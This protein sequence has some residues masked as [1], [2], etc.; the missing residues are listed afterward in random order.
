M[1]SIKKTLTKIL[2]SLLDLS[3]RMGGTYLP[4]G[5]NIDNLT[6]K[7]SGWWVYDQS[8]LSGTFPLATTTSRWGMLKHIQGTS[9]NNGIQIIRPTIYGQNTIILYIRFKGAKVWGDWHALGTYTNR[10][11][12]TRVSNSY[13]NATDVSYLSAYRKNGFL[14]LRGNFHLSASM[15]NN[16]ADVKVATISGWKAISSS[17]M[18]IPAQNGNATLLLN[19]S[20]DGDIIISNYSGINTNS[21]AWFRFMLTVPCAD[22]YE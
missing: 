3:N 18:C 20:S 7:H 2:E 21:Q 9:D 15:P 14:T 16:T 13:V 4:D 1:I 5:T 17:I 6:K 12:I 19:V 8:K 11:T 22:G 10:L